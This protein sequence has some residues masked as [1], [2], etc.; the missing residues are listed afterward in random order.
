MVAEA[1]AA[2]DAEVV[3]VVAV[4]EEVSVAEADLEEAVEARGD[5]AVEET[6][7]AGE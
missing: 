2:E 4:S 1:V 5:A 7:D 3:A 6:E